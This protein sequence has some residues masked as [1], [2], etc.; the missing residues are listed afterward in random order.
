[1]DLLTAAEVASELNI[2]HTQFRAFWQVAKKFPGTFPFPEKRYGRQELWNPV[3]V[4][5]FK[6]DR[7]E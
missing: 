2:S 3:S 5:Q 1:V 4:A 6:A 7:S